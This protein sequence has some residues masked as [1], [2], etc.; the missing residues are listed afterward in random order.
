MNMKIN[1]VFLFIFQFI[2]FFRIDSIYSQT[3]C[4]DSS[5]IDSINMQY[6][7]IEILGHYDA[8]NFHPVC[9]CDSITYSNAFCAY[10]NGVTSSTPGPCSCIEKNFIDTS[11]N[12]IYFVADADPSGYYPVR[13]CDGKNYISQ[14]MAIAYGGVTSFTTDSVPCIDSS[15]IDTSI[16]LSIFPDAPVCGCDKKTYRNKY[17]AFFYGGNLDWQFGRCECIDLNKIDTTVICD[18]IY[19][20]VCGCDRKTYKNQCIAENYYGI[21]YTKPG[22]C[23]CIDSTLI[24]N[25][26]VFISE[27]NPIIYNRYSPVCGCDSI[28]YVN[29]V[30]AEFVFGVSRWTMGYCKC[31]DSTQIDLSA[32]CYDLYYPIV[33]CDGK[34]YKNPCIA[35][36]YFGVM[37]WTFTDC[38][39]EQLIDKSIECDPHFNYNPVCGCNHVTYPNECYAFNHAGVTQWYYGYC[40]N[41][42]TCIDTFLINDLKYCSDYYD[43]VCGCDSITYNNECIAKYRYGVKSWI[44]GT[45]TT[46]V[47]D[48]KINNSGDIKIFPNP[49]TDYIS[50]ADNNME[51]DEFK[52]FNLLGQQLLTGKYYGK[53][54]VNSLIPGA[55]I[56]SIRKK[57]MIKKGVFIKQ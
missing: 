50:I 48:I 32:S 34:F 17:E 7:C 40:I 13:G 35:R 52:I 29:P 57:N 6:I 20:P 49:S 46:N 10:T 41:D 54:D 5:Q 18:T 14:Y 43:P 53:I 4:I 11:L 55:Y 38:I 44:P 1:L 9:G 36:Y 47:K 19:E 27:I 22:E 39:E 33:G 56:L 15:Y 21:Q 30:V 51:I 23:P 8:G 3:E 37:G 12:L 2:F 25:D 28:V 24:L 42:S 45:C 31:I 26:S 16:D